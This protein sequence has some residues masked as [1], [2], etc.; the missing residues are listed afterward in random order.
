MRSAAI[1]R[2]FEGR[3][4]QCK[5]TQSAKR[6]IVTVKVTASGEHMSERGAEGH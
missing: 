3:R 2:F 5:V 4:T 1:Q 6:G